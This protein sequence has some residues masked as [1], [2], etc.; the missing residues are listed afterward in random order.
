MH[1]PLPAPLQRAVTDSADGAVCAACRLLLFPMGS[2]R[3]DNVERPT[4]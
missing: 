3:N 2:R 4:I 1:V